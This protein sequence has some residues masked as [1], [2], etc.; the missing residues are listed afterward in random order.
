M[1]AGIFSGGPKTFETAD[2]EYH[3]SLFSN[4]KSTYIGKYRL[5]LICSIVAGGGEEN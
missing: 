5:T 3:L 4:A 1:Y 2:I